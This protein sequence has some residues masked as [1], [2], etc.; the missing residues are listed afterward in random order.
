[1]VVIQAADRLHPSAANAL[2]K[3]LEEPPQQTH[4]VLVTGRPRRLPATVR[5]RCVRVP[6]TLPDREV[7]A[8]WLEEQGVGQSS[9]ALA[10]AGFS[11]LKARELNIPAFWSERSVLIEQVL[12]GGRFD[13]VAL[14]ERAGPETLPALVGGLQRW[15]YDLLLSK[16]T[17][18]VRY[19]P[20]CAQILHRLS[21]RVASR[22][23]VRFL[24]ELQTVARALE[25]P[26]N[27]RLVME[28][29]LIGY[30]QVLSVSESQ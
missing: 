2:L 5:S 29:C 25:H 20:D 10:Q 21:A 28:R 15:C 3:T 8:Q 23:L 27:P 11:P 14:S 22:P 1:V 19:N 9:L 13:P 30:K 26:L 16:S 6:F 18:R 24:R 7:A 4:L 12:S 17:G